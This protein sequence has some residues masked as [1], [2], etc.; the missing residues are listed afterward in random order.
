MTRAPF[1]GAALT[2]GR[3]CTFS[4]SLAA[5]TRDAYCVLSCGGAAYLRAG[6]QRG[7][8][9][10]M[11]CASVRHSYGCQSAC[12]LRAILAGCRAP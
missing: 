7:L 10:E 5:C 2:F 9:L 3:T 11:R 4:S 12:P 6:C 1:I 8:T